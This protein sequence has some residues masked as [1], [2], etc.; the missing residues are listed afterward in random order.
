MTTPPD[1]HVE[2]LFG[3]PFDQLDGAGVAARI[4]DAARTRRPLW[5]STANLD[6]VVTAKR[7]ASFHNTL[8]RSDLVTCDGM[9]VMALATIRGR[10]FK[11]RVTGVE[12]FRRLRAGEAGPLRIGFFGAEGDE[13]ERASRAL[14]DDPSTPLVGA[15][16]Y[17]P[18]HGSAEALSAPEHLEA[19]RAMNADFLVIALTAVKGQEWIAAN[20]ERLGIPVVAHLGAVIRQVAG[21]TEEAP[22]LMARMGLEWV[23]RAINEPR[24]RSRYAQNFVA[25]PGLVLS[26]LRERADG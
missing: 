5:L 24:L 26:A 1:R 22:S 12:I 6:W 19:V 25:L 8:C 11:A 21:D 4:G 15:G 2:T 16:G 23:Y 14:N 20:H 13:S 10:P 18:G 3:I 17:N 7:S 9:P